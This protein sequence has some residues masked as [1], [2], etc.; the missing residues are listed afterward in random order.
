M[1][2]FDY[3]HQALML[4]SIMFGSASRHNYQDGS[5]T[6]TKDTYAKTG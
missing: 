1:A 3:S 2:N 5:K 6:D 4:S